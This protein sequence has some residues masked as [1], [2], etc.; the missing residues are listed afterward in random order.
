MSCENKSRSGYEIRTE[1]LAM[2][3]DMAMKEYDSKWR[4]YELYL[5]LED[6]SGFSNIPMEPSFPTM[7][8]ILE[9]ANKMN[10]FIGN[11]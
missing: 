11:K 8:V 10:G 9:I 4:S 7:D 5:M 2:A 3:K 6:K 1:I